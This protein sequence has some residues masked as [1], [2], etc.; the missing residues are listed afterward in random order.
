MVDSQKVVV[1]KSVK[2]AT[3][4]LAALS[5]AVRLLIGTLDLSEVLNRLTELVRTHL[6]VDVVRIWLEEGAPGEFH[7]KAQ[8]GVTATPAPHRVQLRLGEGLVGAVMAHRAPLALPDLLADPRIENRDWMKAERLVSFLGVPLF[9]KDEP[10]G[11][12][13]MMTRTPRH[14]TPEEVALAETL[15]VPAAIAIDNARLYRRAEE[16]AQKLTALSGLTWRITSAPDSEEV[17][18]AIAHAATT[19]LGAQMAEVWVDDPG[20]Q[21]LRVVERY[22]LDPAHHSLVADFCVLPYGRGAVGSVFQARTSEYFL[23]IQ[24]D[25]RWLNQPLAKAADLHSCAAVPLVTGDHVVGVLLILFGARRQFTPEEQE[26]I[27]LLAEHAAIAIEK[28]RLLQESRIHQAHLEALLEVSRHLSR[29]QPLES[30]L[31]QIAETCGYLL[32]ADSVAFRLL[33]GD[34]LVLTGS[35]GLADVGFLPRLKMGESIVGVVASTGEA[36][37]LNDPASDP[38]MLPAHREAHR[39][40]GTH[41]FLGV[42]VK[43]GEQVAG[44]LSVRTRRPREFSQ[45][46]LTLATA[47]AS[48]AAI[49]L[50]NARLVKSLQQAVDDL[51]AAQERLVRGE[52]LRAV[53]ELA[54]GMAHHLN[55]LLAVILGRVQLLLGKTQAPELR[56]SLEIV[57]RTTLDGAEVVR[58]VQGFA[59]VKPISEPVQVDLNELA[60][61]VLEL[62]QLRWQAEAQVRG[63]QINASLEP[64]P[65]PTVTGDPASLREV[66]MNLLL[67]AID[68]LPAGGRITIRTWESDGWVRCAVS[69]TGV[70]MPEE[71]RQRAL[72]PFFTTKGPKST[73]LGL[74][75]SYGIMRRHGGDLRIESVPNQGTT[76]TLTLPVSRTPEPSATEET[77][78]TPPAKIMVIDDEPE[79]RQ[80]LAEIL[81]GQG[82]LVSQAA[83]GPEGISRF[84]E[85]RHDLVFTD[86]G[87]PGM[88]GWQVAAAVKALSPETPV[89]LVTG[90]VDHPKAASVEAG[91]VDAVLMKPFQTTEVAATVARALARRARSS[92]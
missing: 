25:S 37:I 52:T 5:E 43:V 23:D 54:S 27:G 69:D 16:R 89:V 85:D 83:D 55:N 7:L 56:R 28:A 21:N 63:I 39:R 53:G 61:E 19:L 77:P 11:A 31:G 82:H 4:E 40:L 3:A 34:D 14:F 22:G 10:F 38:R 51:K 12:L 30:L 15:A 17:F 20:A 24:G 78:E 75:V 6:D 9:V 64:G 57:E 36:I 72:E 32:G 41:A 45:E 79:V 18:R 46:D 80:M 92:G 47:F 48:Q 60:Q 29:V 59:R 73:G 13:A 67:N 33:E 88:T 35:W 76:V 74:S 86:L 44:V 8:A 65:I 90:W 50:E 87:M 66:L 84:Q 2:C 70:G 26:L 49:A 62:T 42:P 81:A 58:R 71:V 68:A 1:S 91:R